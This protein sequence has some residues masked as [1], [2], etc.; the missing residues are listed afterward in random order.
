[1]FTRRGL[2]AL[3]AAGAT[4]KSRMTSKERVDRAL[5][6][7]EVDRPPFT[8]WHHFGLQKEPGERFARATLDFHRKFR[9]DLVKVMSDFP[10]PRPSGKWYELSVESNPFPE[11]LRAL[12][13]IRDGLKGD[14]YFV[15]TLFNPWNQAEKLSSK[16][17]VQQL[18]RDN[19]KVL[20]AALETIAESEANHVKKA[21]ATGASGIF[22]AIANAQ[23]GI[24]TREEYAKF[25]QP[26][27]RIV[28]QAAAGSKI[29]VLHLHGPKVYLD[30]FYHGW[31]GAT[32]INYGDQETGVPVSKV[33]AAYDGV[34]MGG[35]DEINYRSLTPADLKK[36]AD[37]ARAAAGRKFILAPGCSVPDDSADEELSRLP[38]LLGA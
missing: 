13:M 3:A 24:L 36:Q 20:L 25:S 27:D 9:T 38:A 6:G 28:L 29:N 33:R 7:E 22:L 23:D 32:V 18:K 8:F 10:Y 35:L 17:Q 19:P 15:E 37:A 1:M 5:R 4:A 26:F 34:I 31:T 30:L 14:A 11:Q 21:I 16:E 12:E 2:L